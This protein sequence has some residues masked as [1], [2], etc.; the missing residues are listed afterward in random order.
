M[1]HD[2][3][4]F[5][6][7]HYPF[8]RLPDTALGALSFHLL[9][10]YYPKGETIFTEGSKP[11]E[12]LYIIRKGAVSLQA[13]GTEVD[14][15]EEGDTFGYPSLLSGE[16]PTVTAV[17]VRDTILY[18]L[19]KEVFLKLVE[20]YEEFEHFFT[21]SLAKKLASSMKLL[22]ISHR[23]EGRFERFLTLKVGELKIR[24]VPIVQGDMTVTEASRLMRDK[25]LTCLIV[26]NGGEE[27]IVTERD[28]IKKVLAESRDPSKTALKEIM[29]SPIVW[30]DKE[31]FLF[32]A[33][34]KMAQLNIRRVVVKE[35]GRILGVLED[36][37]IIVQETRNL[38]VITKEIERA[39]DVKELSYL[40]S[41]TSDMVADLFG[42]G[43]KVD[44][45]A[46]LIS[47]VNDKIIGKALLFAIRKVGLEP[48]VS[49]SVMV[50][51]SEGRREQTLKTDQDNALIYD[52]TYPSLDVDVEDYFSQLGKVFIDILTEIGFPP[53]PGGVMASNSKWRKGITSW[54]K[55]VKD[56]FIKPDPQNTLEVGMFLDFRNAYGSSDL[57]EEL[58]DFVIESIRE[59]DLFVAY[60]LL[61]A[62]RFRPPTGFL[63]WFLGGEKVDLKKVGIFPITH[64]VRALA[65]KSGIRDTSTLGR[66][67]KLRELSVLPPDLS[68][69]LKEAFSFLQTVR[70]KVQIEA[71]KKGEKPTNEVNL[72]DLPKLERDMLKESLRIVSEFQDFLDRRFLASIPR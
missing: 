40:Y 28:I 19:P 37:D 53:C 31:D 41:V 52:D 23:T 64:G 15:L 38:L 22:R 43:L 30:V 25:N 27:G 61:D 24:E 39:K 33:L 13:Q 54:K 20:K 12:Y 36:R 57:V 47:E 51:G 63:R 18:L 2:V 11:L 32:D 58:R 35:N 4:N 62:V 67:E 49:F 45:I 68:S 17:T 8:S 26:R 21:K 44:H 72:G 50:L 10:R 16:P 70:L 59:E 66:I 42:E 1:I 71:L 7:E 60:M 9:V 48:P 69:D 34:L 46:R 56:W 6:K 55:T 5:L 14:F 65:L 3:E 29:S